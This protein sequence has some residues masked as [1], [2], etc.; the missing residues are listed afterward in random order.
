MYKVLKAH[1]T[2]SYKNAPSNRH[3]KKS[4][5]SE[6]QQIDAVPIKD[7]SHEQKP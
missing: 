2:S 5:V 7:A 4:F 1:S 6:Q 3:K